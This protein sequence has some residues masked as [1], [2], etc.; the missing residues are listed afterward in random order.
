[1]HSAVDDQRERIGEH[2]F[3]ILKE[4][5]CLSRFEAAFLSFHEECTKQV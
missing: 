3:C 2:C 4:T 1:M 5:S